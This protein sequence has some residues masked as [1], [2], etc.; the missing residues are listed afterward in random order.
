MVRIAMHLHRRLLARVLA[1]RCG[2][3]DLR[4]IAHFKWDAGKEEEI[5][6]SG[7]MLGWR[8]VNNW[9]DPQKRPFR[10]VS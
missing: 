4:H 7:W 8:F 10:E 1:E 6:V 5:Q 2:N 3:V 9:G